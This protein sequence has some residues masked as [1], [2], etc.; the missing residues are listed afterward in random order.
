MLRHKYELKVNLSKLKSIC[1]HLV[2]ISD[3]RRIFQVIL[4]RGCS[5]VNSEWVSKVQFL[6]LAWISVFGL[7]LMLWLRLDTLHDFVGLSLKLMVFKTICLKAL[8]WSPFQV[9]ELCSKDYQFE[10]LSPEQVENTCFKNLWNIP[11]SWARISVM[12]YFCSF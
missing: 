8:L 10:T 9:R 4:V 3:S 7:A 2:D 5:V 6:G 12:Y 11:A 1:L